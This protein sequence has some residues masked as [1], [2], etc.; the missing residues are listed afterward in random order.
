MKKE[1]ID[2][3][4]QQIEVIKNKRIAEG[5]V[6]FVDFNKHFKVGDTVTV[7][8][9]LPQAD[10]SFKVQNFQGTCVQKR[11]RT[12]LF[13]VRRETIGNTAVERKFHYFSDTI[14]DI[15]VVKSRKYVRRAKI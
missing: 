13:L 1:I 4:N 12:Q 9:K 3:E 8:V 5:K 7:G 2:F 11:S 6:N 10:G 15:S 14:S